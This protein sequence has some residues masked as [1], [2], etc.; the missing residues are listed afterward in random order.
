[1]RR[2]LV[3]ALATLALLAGCASAPVRPPRFYVVQPNDTLYS[4]AW[5]NRLDYRDLAAWN[6]IGPD[7]RITVGERL[8]LRP[9][10]GVAA[11]RLTPAP[12]RTTP[13]VRRP[14]VARPPVPPPSVR[15]AAAAALRWTWPTHRIGRVQRLVNGALLIDGRLGQT[16]RA[17]AAGHVV[18][19]GAGIPGFGLL[20]IIKHDA[21]VLSAYAYNAAVLVHQGQWVTA[22]EPIARM[23]SDSR[24]VPMLYFEIRADGRTIDPLPYLPP[25]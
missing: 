10:S 21:E 14:R 3:A 22:G 20:V 15:S 4:I 2:S 19:T 17:A 8:R 9:P 11:R 7:F 23:G 18:Y 16:V 5:R 12:A 6:H 1:V 13:G 25:R 24:Q